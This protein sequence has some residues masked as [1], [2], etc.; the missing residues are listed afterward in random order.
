MDWK[1][2]RFAGICT[3]ATVALITMPLNNPDDYLKVGILTIAS[4]IGA[5]IPDI[6]EPSSYIGS[7]L[8]FL[9]KIIKS[10]CG[11]RGV[12]HYPFI[13]GCFFALLTFCSLNYNYPYKEMVDL[14]FTG[15]ILGYASH[16]FVDS[17]TIKGIS[18]LWPVTRKSFHLLRLET[19]NKTHQ[20]F[21]KL[22]FFI[23][24]IYTVYWRFFLI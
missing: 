13:V 17:L 19:N 9:S 7:K 6:D 15:I 10:T 1:T 23:F 16:I 22:I 2:H 21:V 5:F 12:F 20:I 4:G 8:K 3:G 14:F 11:H 18:L 24:L